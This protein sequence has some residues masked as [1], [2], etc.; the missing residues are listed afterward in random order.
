MTVKP[1]LNGALLMP[2]PTLPVRAAELDRHRPVLLYCAAGGRSAQALR[3]LQSQGFGKAKHLADGIFDW[4]GS[5][6]PVE[7]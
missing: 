6:Y 1:A 2:L 5:G 7:R 3:F 4:T